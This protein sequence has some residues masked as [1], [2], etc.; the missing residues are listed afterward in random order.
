MAFKRSW[1][2]LPSAPP[3]DTLR[4]LA[5]ADGGV[6][7]VIGSLSVNRTSLPPTLS[8]FKI[9]LISF[10]Y[11]QLWLLV[12]ASVAVEYIHSQAASGLLGKARARKNRAATALPNGD[13]QRLERIEIR[14]RPLF[15]SGPKPQASEHVQ[16]PPIAVSERLTISA[17]ESNN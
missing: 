4:G 11:N 10:F 7:T 13:D 1:V 8:S 6:L 3:I 14:K 15:S 9:R 16:E 2:R 12:T 17:R 5:L